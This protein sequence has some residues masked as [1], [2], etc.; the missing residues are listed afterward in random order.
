M[1]V[2]KLQYLEVFF[3]F[4]KDGIFL[5]KTVFGLQKIYINS[6]FLFK[7]NKMKLFCSNKSEVRITLGSINDFFVAFSRGFFFELALRGVGFKSYYFGL[8][9]L[10]LNLGY[11]HFIIYKIPVDVIIFLKKINYIFLVYLNN[12]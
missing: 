12:L 11:S 2:S 4:P 10:F 1:K 3:Y 8:N 9:K 5:L 6:S 7:L